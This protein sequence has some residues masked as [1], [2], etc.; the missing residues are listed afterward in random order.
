MTS[1]SPEKEE[2]KVPV[3]GWEH[4][5]LVL[6]FATKWPSCQGLPVAGCL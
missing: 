1:I 4:G 2:A 3:G 5:R 6:G